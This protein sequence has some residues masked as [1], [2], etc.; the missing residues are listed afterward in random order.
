M[1]FEVSDLVRQQETVWHE[2]VVN[3][4]KPLQTANNHA[5]YVF[6]CEVVHQRV[7]VEDAPPHFYDI[8]VV[9]AQS[10]AVP[11]NRAI[12]WLVGFS[13]SVFSDYILNGV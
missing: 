4:E 3:W 6:L 8:Q 7:P 13:V 12:S 9:V 2:L 5:E 1:V 11:Q 10:H